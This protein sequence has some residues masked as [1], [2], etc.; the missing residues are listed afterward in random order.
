MSWHPILTK[1]AVVGTTQDQQ[2]KLIIV[3]SVTSDTLDYSA[4]VTKK[5][6]D[7]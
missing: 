6:M 5:T 3:D 2:F 7:V 1:L 4:N